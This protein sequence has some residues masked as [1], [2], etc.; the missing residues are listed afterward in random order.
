MPTSPQGLRRPQTLLT[1]AITLVL[2]AAVLLVAPLS[3]RAVVSGPWSA[4]MDLSV[5]GVDSYNPQLAM[6]SDGMVVTAAWAQ[7]NGLL[8][9]TSLDG[10]VTWSDPQLLGDAGADNPRIAMSSD[11]ARQTVVWIDWDCGS[12]TYCIQATATANSGADWGTVVTLS[13]VPADGGFSLLDI[14]SRANGPTVTVVWSESSDYI[15]WMIKSRTSVDGG[16]N[17]EAATELTAPGDFYEPVISGSS[18]ATTTSVAWEDSSGAQSVISARTSTDSLASWDATVTIGGTGASGPQLVSSSDG[19]RLIALWSQGGDPRVFS[20]RSTNSGATWTPAVRISEAGF[21][22]SGNTSGPQL[23]GSTVGTRAT[24]VW[25]VYTVV[26]NGGGYTIMSTSTSTDGATWTTPVAVSPRSPSVGPPRLAASSDGL[27]VIAMWHQ[28]G[29]FWTATSDDGGVSWSS[30]VSLNTS[31]VSATADL[32]VA[33]NASGSRT[34]ALWAAGV[35]PEFSPPTRHMQAALT[36]TAG[37]LTFTSGA[38]VNTAVGSS[39]SLTVTVTNSGGSSTMPSAIAA[40]GSGVSVTGGTCSVFSEIAAGGTCTVILTWT[41]AS[42]GVLSGA[43]LTV[44]YPGGASASSGL[45]LSGSATSGGGGGSGGSTT[46]TPSPSP[47]SS[48]TTPVTPAPTSTPAPAPAA[49]DLGNPSQV[50]SS[51]L[52]AI[53]PSEVGLIPPAEFG[54]IPAAAFAA[55]TPQQVAAL[56]PGQVNAIRPGRAAELTP[57]AVAEMSPGQVASLRPRS[58]GALQPAALVA[59]TAE[60]LSALRPAAIAFIPPDVLAR[61][62]VQ[63]LRAL[64]PAQVR[65]MTPEQLAALTP[66]Q[67]S[68][69]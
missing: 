48:T 28:D 9:R 2:A 15:S 41:P 58:V 62:S 7:F 64:T 49:P 23:T 44:S 65:A 39:A 57:S 40:A 34:V 54:Q 14:W 11:G 21:G 51:Q 52:A 3:A 8:T 47:S 26:N 30:P 61:L 38:F 35:W 69:L 59:L 12:H 56:T 27:S 6:S 68:A 17:W 10:G 20:A 32:A 18:D 33:A 36:P 66:R 50:T 43:T 55:L 16:V 29:S 60:Q 24:A 4:P 1:L 13:T 25:R 22:S 31:P 67:R 42:A 46:P 37:P 45:T 63:Q 53:P 19:S 5:S